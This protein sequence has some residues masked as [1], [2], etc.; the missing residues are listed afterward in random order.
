MSYPYCLFGP[1]FCFVTVLNV[2]TLKKTHTKLVYE[3][4]IDDI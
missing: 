3:C 1:S 4:Q 2:L